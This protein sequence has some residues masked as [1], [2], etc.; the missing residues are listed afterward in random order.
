MRHFVTGKKGAT[1]LSSLPAYDNS[2]Q[3]WWK[4]DTTTKITGNSK[5]DSSSN[6]NTVTYHLVER[7]SN[8]TYEQSRIKAIATMTLIDA[9]STRTNGSNHVD[10]NPDMIQNLKVDKERSGKNF[11]FEGT[12]KA[13]KNLNVLT[14]NNLDQQN[15]IEQ[16][17]HVGLDLDNKLV[18]YKTNPTAATQVT[19]QSDSQ[20]TTNDTEAV[21]AEWSKVE[22]YVRTSGSNKNFGNGKQPNH[23]IPKEFKLFYS[24]DGE[25]WTP[26][27][28]QT[29]RFDTDFIQA[30]AID[31][32]SGYINIHDSSVGNQNSTTF[33]ESKARNIIRVTNNITAFAIEFK[34]VKAKYMKVE[35]VSQKNT[36]TSETARTNSFTDN[37]H[38]FLP[39]NNNLPMGSTEWQS[40]F[41][42][43][44]P[45][46]K[47]SKVTG[48]LDHAVVEVKFFSP[49]AEHNP[50]KKCLDSSKH[51]LCFLIKK[52]NLVFGSFCIYKLN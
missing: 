31:K 44:A 40:Y 48:D 37:N 41:K 5:N 21:E 45:E 24:Q 33:Q 43:N 50:Y 47:K 13:S 2:K 4:V 49:S 29:H 11:T 25:Q 35:W 27:L 16:W 3:D 14:D 38:Y 28:N 10:R 39:H 6:T 12:A 23:S 7:N 36:L 51:F 46:E 42:S 32:D 20:S 18:F 52:I 34:P 1:T 30:N 19:T 26:V 8:A 22:L 17:E 15:R 9:D